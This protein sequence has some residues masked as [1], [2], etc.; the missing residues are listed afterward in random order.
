M[1]TFFFQ[2]SHFVKVMYKNNF[3]NF[4]KVFSAVTNIIFS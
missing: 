3:K 1:F 2:K 4:L